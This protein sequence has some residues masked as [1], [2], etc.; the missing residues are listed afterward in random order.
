LS[1]LGGAAVSGRQAE[2]SPQISIVCF[3]I[4]V[5]QVRP[6]APVAGPVLLSVLADLGVSSSAARSLLLRMRREGWITSE[7]SGRQAHYRLSPVLSAAEGRLDRHLRGRQPEWNGSFTG[8]LF[9]VPERYRSYRD[10]LRRTA[11]LLG[12]VTLR[13]GLLIATTD[14]YSELVALLPAQPSGSQLLA[15]TLAFSTDDSRRM[16]RQLW[17]LDGFATRCQKAL[18]T[19]DRHTTA[20]QQAPIRGA[21]A[22]RAFAAATLPLFEATANDPDLPAEL[23]P[24][25]W[26]AAQLGAALRRAFEVFGPSLIAYLGRLGVTK[27][28]DGLPG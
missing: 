5:A 10:R 22:L 19:A 25:D 12:Y 17:D 8:V 15:L 1:Y 3:A 11:Q 14:R 7:R 21:E 24:E 18:A 26:P 6:G 9:S 28:P 16:A 13:P 23:L 2:L 4:G 27:D 20:A